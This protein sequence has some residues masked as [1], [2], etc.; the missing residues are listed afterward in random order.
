MP[1]L[2]PGGATGEDEPLACHAGEAY[3]PIMSFD[4]R[5]FLVASALAAFVGPAA[6]QDQALRPEDFGA[7]GNGVA[8]DTQAFRRL[9][10]EVN[11]RGGGTI[12]LRPGRTYIVG[13]QLLAAGRWSPA[14]ILELGRLSLPLTIVGNGARLVAQAGLRF[15]TFDP[16]TGKRVD[17]ALPYVDQSDLAFPYHAM[18][19]VRDCTAPVEIRDLELDGNMTGLRIGGRFG[20][21]GWQVPGTGLLLIGNRNAEIVENVFTH[22]HGQDGA[23]FIGDAARAG[24]GTV[25]RLV[26][27]RNGRQGLSITGGRGYDLVDCEFGQSSRSLVKSAPSAGVDIEAETGSIEDISFTRCRFV[28]NVGC[29]FVAD[30]GNS[31]NLRFADCRF[32]GTTSW[33]AWPNKPGCSFSGCTF[34]GSVVH[35]FA[36]PDPR[37]AARFLRCTF[38]DDPALSPTR[39]VY[40]GGGPIV[41]LAQSENVLFDKC[42]F[43]LVASGLL[44]WSWKATYRDC[45]MTQKAA[46]SANPKGR[47]LGYSTIS[48]RVDLYGS[49][50]QGTLLLNGSRLPRGPMGVPAW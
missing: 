41:N 25:T 45:R 20:D 35:A 40:T 12:E 29:G 46:T 23:M 39:K 31:R 33:S 11:R 7:L 47:Y 32:I 5:E 43:R 8:N 1:N 48:G 17:H 13:S 50:I 26:S 27:R 10:A 34:V 16:R 15:G 14:P 44:P 30:S 2:R 49:M 42:T 19:H 37:R 18:I 21:T 38:T 3:R 22:D 6:R 28:D 36:D 24:R 9:G 4:R